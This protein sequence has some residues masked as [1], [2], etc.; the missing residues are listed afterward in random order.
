VRKLWLF[1]SIALSVFVLSFSL[2]S[3]EASGELSGS[4]T[5]SIHALLTD[6]FPAWNLEL[7]TL[8]W[9]VRKAAHLGSYFVL[10]VAWS[11]TLGLY[12]IALQ[13]IVVLGV[14]LAVFGELLQLLAQD[15]GPSLFDAL[16][17]NGTGY[18]IGVL[19]Y[20]LGRPKTH[21]NKQNVS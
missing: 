16:V 7:D 6:W 1:V 3:G 19:L 4:L 14:G 13:W 15:R 21:S 8:H 18:L 2:Q 11:H 10:G 5:A 17:F 20:R 12:R 9:L